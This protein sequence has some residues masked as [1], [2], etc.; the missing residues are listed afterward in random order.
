MEKRNK[1]EEEEDGEEEQG[2][3]RLRIGRRGTRRRNKKRT[4]KQ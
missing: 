1:E 2:R 4:F 3:G